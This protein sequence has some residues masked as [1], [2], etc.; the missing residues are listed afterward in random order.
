[1][2]IHDHRREPEYVQLQ[3]WRDED[4]GIEPW[5]SAVAAVQPRRIVDTRERSYAMIRDGADV[6]DYRS[7]ALEPRRRVS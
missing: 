7:G 2:V 6:R 3:R 1:M 5:S 4:A